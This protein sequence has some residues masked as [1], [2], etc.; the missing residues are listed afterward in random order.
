MSKLS[1]IFK[2]EK[3]QKEQSQEELNEIVPE[4]Q[5][6]LNALNSEF[7]VLLIA[8]L[9]VSPSGIF[10]KVKIIL[11]KDVQPISPPQQGVQK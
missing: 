10:P 11:A 7:G 4:Y 2:N 5:K 9:E 6:R 3:K 1:R 8:S